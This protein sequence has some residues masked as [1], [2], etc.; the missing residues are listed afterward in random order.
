ME[1][2]STRFGNVQFPKDL[3]IRI[4]GGLLGFPESERF[5]V[6]E[7]DA[8]ESPFRWLHS[9]DDP[10]LAFII[11]DPHALIPDY[12]AK[13]EKDVHD[14]FGPYDPQD[15]STIAVITVPP[16]RPAEMT[17]NLRAPVVVKFSVL[18][19]KQIILTDDQ[20]SLSHR[21]FSESSPMGE[22]ITG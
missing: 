21:I 19:A 14:A 7:H 3:V 17:A 13:I 5:V 1:I 8:E 22:A 2:K 16:D 11:I 20:F 15:V 9:A 10:N 4:E 18:R 6:L 12:L